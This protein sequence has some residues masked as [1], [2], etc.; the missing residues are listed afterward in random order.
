M[1]PRTDTPRQTIGHGGCFT[2]IYS[3]RGAGGYQMFGITPMPIYEAGP[4][5]HYLREKM[6]MFS[7]G[8][9]VKFKPIERAEYDAIL[10]AVAADTFTPR[11]RPF[12]FDQ[13]EFERDIDGYNARVMGVLNN[14]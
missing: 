2:A 13:R 4:G 14:A 5:P 8:D 11:V 3:V 7:P 12:T 1:R 6:V 10:A 9:I